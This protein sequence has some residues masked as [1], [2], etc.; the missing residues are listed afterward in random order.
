MTDAELPKTFETLAARL[1]EHGIDRR[2]VPFVHAALDMAVSRLPKRGH[3]SGQAVALA[4]REV[5][6]SAF[7]ITSRIVMEDFG[8]HSTR[9]IGQVVLEMV[10]VGIMSATE[11]DTIDDFNDVYPWES[12][13]QDYPLGAEFALA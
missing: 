8:L 11:D 10:D 2:V 12:L 9:D 1:G 7:G 3:V 13:D 4:F 6:W 5:L